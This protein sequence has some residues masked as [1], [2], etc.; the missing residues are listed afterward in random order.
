MPED[1]SFWKDG[2]A[3]QEQ[4]SAFIEEVLAGKR[5]PSGASE[6]P[7]AEEWKK[8]EARTVVW[9]TLKKEVWEGPRPTLLEVFGKFRQDNDK[10]LDE[11]NR[12]AAA[13]AEVAPDTNVMLGRYD[14]G[15]NHIPSFLPRQKYASHTDWFFVDPAK[16]EADRMV[17]LK[18]SDAALKQIIS[19]L[20]KQAGLSKDMANKIK[21]EVGRLAAEA[22]AKKMEEEEARKAKQADEDDDDI[23]AELETVGSTDAAE[24]KKDEAKEEL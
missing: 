9:K 4:L 11:G 5:E 13:L 7:P 1:G 23:D 3:A 24:E 17:K 10:R 8:G 14:T 15:A 18:K 16:P 22:E 21:L 12:I 20:Q 6:M 2:E 19:F